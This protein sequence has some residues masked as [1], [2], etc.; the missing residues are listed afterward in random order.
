MKFKIQTQETLS[1]AIKIKRLKQKLK[2]DDC[3]KDL[4]TKENG[5]RLINKTPESF[6]TELEIKH[7]NCQLK[8]HQ[9]KFRPEIK[10]SISL[11]NKLRR[12]TKNKSLPSFLNQ[13][14]IVPQIVE[15]TKANSYTQ[16][17]GK[18]YPNASLHSNRDVNASISDL[19]YF[20]DISRFSLN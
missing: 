17:A 19:L 1:T 10:S 14:T 15:E 13:P 11:P 12:K 4:K 8:N 3:K 18:N 7:I 2:R 20:P 5:F 16:T 9:L 6:K